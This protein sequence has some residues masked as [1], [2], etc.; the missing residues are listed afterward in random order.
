MA[1]R[2]RIAYIAMYCDVPRVSQGDVVPLSSGEDAMININRDALRALG[3]KAVGKQH[4]S[5]MRVAAALGAFFDREKLVFEDRFRV[6]EQ[7]AD[8][9]AFAVVHAA[10]GGEAKKRGF[11]GIDSGGGH[12]GGIYF[13]RRFQ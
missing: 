8:E 9:R 13:R 3:A 4:K 5:H 7:T 11:G 10:C 12:E 1:V 6:V 2:A